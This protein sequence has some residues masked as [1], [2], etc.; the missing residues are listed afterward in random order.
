M[1]PIVPTKDDEREC[2]P[3]I[4]A[5]AGP[6]NASPEGVR[7]GLSDGREDLWLRPGIGAERGPATMS[8]LANVLISSGWKRP[9]RKEFFIWS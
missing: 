8:E 2:V 1:L 3:R 9:L 4:D 5:D 7:M 6:E